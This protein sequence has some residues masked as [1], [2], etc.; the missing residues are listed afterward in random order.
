MRRV[1]SIFGALSS[2]SSSSLTGLFQIW[3]GFSRASRLEPALADE[4]LYVRV[5]YISYGR[6]KQGLGTLFSS[7]YHRRPSS[8]G[9]AFIH[10]HLDT[11][12][13]TLGQEI[14]DIRFHHHSSCIRGGERAYPGRMSLQY[15]SWCLSLPCSMFKL[16][17]ATVNHIFFCGCLP[18]T[19][20]VKVQLTIFSQLHRTFL[21][22]TDFP[23]A[24]ALFICNHGPF[25]ILPSQRSCYR[26]LHSPL[27]RREI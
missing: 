1:R 9:C 16:P 27:P 24:S 17:Y 26:H 7:V 6:R 2:S 15:G 22:L 21:N 3:I 5:Q 10:A 11:C 25:F 13:T 8:T 14:S 4:L 19:L 12:D 23:T 18:D 20:S